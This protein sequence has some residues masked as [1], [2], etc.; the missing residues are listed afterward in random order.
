[1]AII[2]RQDRGPIACAC[3]TALLTTLLIV[4][5]V[6]MQGPS[7]AFCE[8]Q[9]GAQPCAF[10]TGNLLLLA[11]AHFTAAFTLL[12]LVP[13]GLTALHRLL[14]RSGHHSHSA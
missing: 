8:T 13:K 5:I 2:D 10:G 4:A 14:F 1:M 7:A 3:S 11:A 9:V 6:L 12:I